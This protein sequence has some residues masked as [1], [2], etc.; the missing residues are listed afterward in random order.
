MIPDECAK[1]IAQFPA[2][3]Q[4]LISDELEA[5]NRIIE[6]GC[7]HPAPD[8]GACLKLANMI[9]TRSRCSDD[10][11]RFV[12][13]DHSGTHSSEISDA[14]RVFFVFEPPL[15]N[16]GAY[17]DINAIRADLEARERASNADMDR[18]CRS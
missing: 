1:K 4:K 2:V 18:S 13:R 6:I 8:D 9:S 3:L 7:G 17:P 12:F 5:G 16:P 10:Q 11:L 15:P 14:Q